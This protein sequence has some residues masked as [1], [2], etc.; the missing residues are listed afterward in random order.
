MYNKT[1]PELI[2]TQFA[3][4]I[5]IVQYNINTYTSILLYINSTY[6][7]L[8]NMKHHDNLHSPLISY[9]SRVR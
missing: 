9:W 5:T 8:N 3:I 2:A 6:I 1:E 7:N 4:R